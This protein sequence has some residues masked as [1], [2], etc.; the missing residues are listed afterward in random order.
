MRRRRPS[1]QLI[2]THEMQLA[3]EIAHRVIF[4]DGGSIVEPGP[5]GAIFGTP[6][7]PRIRDFLRTVS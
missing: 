6:Q 3:R 5:P 1:D 4:M 7:D 2:V